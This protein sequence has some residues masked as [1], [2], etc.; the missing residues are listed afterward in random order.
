[1]FDPNSAEPASGAAPLGRQGPNPRAFVVRHYPLFV[2]MGVLAAQLLLL[3]FQIT[4]SHH[5]R[6]IRVWAVAI[7]DPFQRS[8]GGIADA[9]KRTWKTYRELSQAQQ[10]NQELRVQLAAARSRIQQLSEEAAEVPRLRALLEFKNHLPYSTVTAEVIA[11]SPGES[12]N[13]VFI[14]KGTDAGLTTDLAVI[15]PEGLVGKTI[16]V[17][18]HNTQVLLITDPSSG[19][20]AMLERTRAQG[21]LKGSDGNVSK[22]HYVMN[23][24][25]VSVGEA[26]LSSG[27]DQICPKGV[28]LGNVIRVAEGNIYK[29][30]VVKP[31]VPLN[32]LEAVLVVLKPTVTQQQA[33][34]SLPRP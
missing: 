22:L 10:Q 5:V 23:D 34:N 20:G 11:S 19:I 29:N 18:S 2:L 8:L 7:F 15:T 30:I 27:L 9:T 3:S 6:L 21:I 24:E 14:D 17:F 13:A 31:A 32:H 25:P 1:M 26:V 12:S 4:R 33:L 28:P 16:A